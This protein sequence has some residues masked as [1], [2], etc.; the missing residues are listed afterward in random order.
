MDNTNT[1]TAEK[2]E[3][4]HEDEEE[5]DQVVKVEP[6]SYPLECLDRVQDIQL[7]LDTGT[8]PK[9]MKHFLLLTKHNFQT[10]VHSINELSGVVKR[11]NTRRPTFTDTMEDLRVRLYV[12]GV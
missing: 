7:D 11:E 1:E 5:S 2:P 8:N 10:L 12:N 3:G 4:E 6:K 9:K